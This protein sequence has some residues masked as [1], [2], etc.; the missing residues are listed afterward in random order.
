M[1]RRVP[2]G[3]PEFEQFVYALPADWKDMMRDLGAFTYA[4]KIQ[5]PEGLLRAFFSMVGRINPCGKSQ[6]P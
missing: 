4:G 2:Q 1:P 5:S 3:E 6:G